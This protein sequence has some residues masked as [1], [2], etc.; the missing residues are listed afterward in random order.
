MC[1]SGND[2]HLGANEA[3]PA[4]SPVLL[5]RCAFYGIDD[6]ITGSDVHAK[7]HSHEDLGVPTLPAV[8]RVPGQV[9]TS[10]Y[11]YW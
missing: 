6:L 2:H 1:A 11:V 3:P 8:P 4:L 9:I 5:R 10:L 7:T